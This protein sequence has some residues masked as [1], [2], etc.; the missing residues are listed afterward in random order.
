M[1]NKNKAERTKKIAKGFCFSLL[2][3]VLTFTVLLS[4]V[5]FVLQ[6][7]FC[8]E[9][10]ILQAVRNADYRALFIENMKE[11]Y[12]PLCTTSGVSG[13]VTDAFLEEFVTNELALF[14]IE[15][16][17]TENTEGLDLQAGK[18]LLQEKI[19]RYAVSLRES[20]ELN[21][22]DREWEEIVAGFP[23]LSDYFITSLREAVMLNG[24][25]DLMGSLIR[26]IASFLPYLWAG[27][28]F[29]AV[30]CF[31][32]GFLIGKKKGFLSLI[33]ASFGAAGLIF[34]VLP[35]LFRREGYTMRLNLDPMYL[36]AFLHEVMEGLIDKAILWGALCLALALVCG[37][38]RLVLS[39]TGNKKE[40]PERI[41]NET[42]KE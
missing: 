17:F 41:Q 20:G 29:F 35:L 4:G 30:S 21:V 40:L 3:L 25:Y 39:K 32:L 7:A 8:R 15:R 5:S 37:A 10:A 12:A 19:L 18:G 9:E 23:G 42:E 31:L 28:A 6:S 16:I 11:E 27:L 24:I 26:R 1:E 36:R 22:T 34:T 13:E 2:S 14:P 33:Y 38:I